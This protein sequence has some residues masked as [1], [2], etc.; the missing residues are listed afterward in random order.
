LNRIADA[1][2]LCARGAVTQVELARIVGLSSRHL[3]RIE[4][5]FSVPTA[6]HLVDIATA[7]CVSVDDLVGGPKRLRPGERVRM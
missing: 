1:R 5:G 2:R 4:Q 6:G 7:L 3:R